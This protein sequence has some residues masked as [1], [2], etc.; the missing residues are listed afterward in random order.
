MYSER[1]TY[2]GGKTVTIAT[3]TG[4]VWDIDDGKPRAP[5]LP[6]LSRQQARARADQIAGAEPTSDWV[7]FG[8]P[9]VG[10]N[11]PCYEDG[12]VGP[13]IC[14]IGPDRSLRGR[15]RATAVMR[16]TSNAKRT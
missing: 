4:G 3:E 15:R 5:S 13:M 9:K 10:D 7:P 8:E 14:R 2:L 12:C 16:C 11:V 6:G 1:R